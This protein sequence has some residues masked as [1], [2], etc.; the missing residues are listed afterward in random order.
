[1]RFFEFNRGNFTQPHSLRI[2]FFLTLSISKMIIDDGCQRSLVVVVVVGLVI[3]MSD[4][5]EKK[6]ITSEKKREYYS[7]PHVKA[8]KSVECL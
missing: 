1:M 6:R 7:E 3:Q 2:P 8:A 5:E 4:D